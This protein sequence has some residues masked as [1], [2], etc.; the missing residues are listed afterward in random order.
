VA[1][2][3]TAKIVFLAAED[4]NEDGELVVGLIVAVVRGDTD[5]NEAK[6]ANLLGGPELRPMTLDE[7]GSLA[8]LPGSPHRSG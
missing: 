6:L 4:R 7:I 5:L 8:P 1:K 3:R 2:A